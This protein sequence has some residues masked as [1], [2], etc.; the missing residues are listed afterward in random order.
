MGYRVVFFRFKGLLDIEEGVKCR[1][2]VFCV[3]IR[4][5]SVQCVAF[6]ANVL[7]VTL[8]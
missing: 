1:D 2:M 7:W 5:G 8:S 4:A 3:I 6:T